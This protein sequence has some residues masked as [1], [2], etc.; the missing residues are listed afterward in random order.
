MV[1]GESARTGA[2]TLKG[3]TF[4]YPRWLDNAFTT[5]TFHVGSTI[6]IY[7]QAEVESHFETATGE[8]DTFTFDRNL[9]IVRLRVSGEL[10]FTKGFS[11]GIGSEYLA[12]VG[13]NDQSLFLFGADTGYDVRPGIKIR[14]LRND[15]TGSQLGLHLYGA[16]NGGLRAV[17]QGLLRELALEMA[18]IALE[19]ERIS[20]LVAADFNCAFD[21]VDLTT[22][23]K[24]HRQRWGGGGAFNF[25]QAFNEHW[26]LQMTLGLEG[27]LANYSW[28]YLGEIAAPVLNFYVGASP[29]LNFYPDFPLGLTAEYR[30][31]VEHASYDLTAS[32]ESLRSDEDGADDTSVGHRLAFGVYFTGRRDLML[33]ALLGLSFV[34]DAVTIGEEG[35]QPNAMVI[36]PQFDMRYFF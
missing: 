29:S 18:E 21:D 27:A 23:I 1:D 8:I 31:E 5:T 20:C 22:A 34:S 4:A 33:G 10:A 7:D 2:R 12:Q 35:E 13:V 28:R 16:F 36:A 14:L 11:V 32:E 19:Q 24:L 30:F 17:P 9:V 3:H 6:E 26:G 25:A 15:R